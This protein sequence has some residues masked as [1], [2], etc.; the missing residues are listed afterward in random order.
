MTSLVHPIMS[1]EIPESLVI[2]SKAYPLVRELVHKYRVMVIDT[3]P[4]G[5]DS[6]PAFNSFLL[7]R[8]DGIIVGKV[9]INREGQNYF[10]SVT[11]RKERGRTADDR[12]TYYA[13]KVSSLMRTIDKQKLLPTHSEE[14]LNKLSHLGAFVNNVVAEHDDVNKRS[15]YGGSEIHQML[16]VVFGYQSVNSLS[17]DSID[18]FRKSL[19]EYEQVDK[20]REIRLNMV[21]EVFDKPIKFIMYDDTKTF[22]TGSLNLGVV[23]DLQYRVDDVKVAG[24]ECKRVRTFMDDPD[25]APRMA[26][27]KVAVKNKHPDIEF[28]GE[29]GFFPVDG[30]GYYSELGIY[31][32]DTDGWRYDHFPA[33]PRWIFLT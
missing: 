32:I 24:M 25:I 27:L 21:R 11:M 18:K 29:E 4:A 17:Q 2:M 1:S 26:M 5:W 31:K 12:M 20:T 23:I 7:S 15:P 16:K 14:V 13:A 8:D 3:K 22:V 9:G 19:D 30:E 10:R 6:T 33:K 28:V